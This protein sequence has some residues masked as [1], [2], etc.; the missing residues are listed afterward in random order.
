VKTRRVFSC[1]L[2]L[3]VLLAGCRSMRGRERPPFRKISPAVAYELM[4]DNPEMLVLDLRAPQEFLG[5]TGHIRRA[6]NI[7]LDRLPFRLLEISA[8]REETLLVYCSRGGCEQ[9]GMAVL[10]SSGFQDAI[11]MDGGIDAWIEAG[12]KTE[13]PGE[14]AGRPG[15]RQG[16]R[17]PEREE[18][19]G[20]PGTQVPPP[21][22]PPEPP[23]Q[24]PPSA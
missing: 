7:P 20:S 3:A 24:D 11:L 12:F 23:P 14:A 6:V 1:L 8:W 21:P 5:E 13:L 22:P 9:E 17:R 16:P 18:E 2:L 15:A 19:T 10:A 4:R